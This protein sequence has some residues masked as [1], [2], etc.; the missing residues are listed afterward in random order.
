[1][2]DVVECA[3]QAVRIVATPI[4]AQQVRIFSLHVAG[5]TYD[6][7]CEATGYSWTQVNRHM[8]RARSRVRARRDGWRPAAGGALEGT[9]NKF[10]KGG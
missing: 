4:S 9:P 8:V 2:A 6:E 1:M 5:L 3:P 7:I 10:V